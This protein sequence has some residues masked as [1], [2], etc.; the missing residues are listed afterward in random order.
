MNTSIFPILSVVGL[1]LLVQP[2]CGVEPDHFD[3][4]T[5]VRNIWGDPRCEALLRKTYIDACQAID[6][7][8]F[9]EILPR[10]AALLI[11]VWAPL[12]GTDCQ[13]TL[14]KGI[15]L[16]KGG[17]SHTLLVDVVKNED[18]TARCLE[19]SLQTE[20]EE[21]STPAPESILYPEGSLVAEILKT[22]HF[23]K[24]LD[25]DSRV[26]SLEVSFGQIFNSGSLERGMGYTANIVL[27]KKDGAGRVVEKKGL[28][29]QAL[30]GMDPV[31]NNVEG[32][33]KL[34]PGEKVFRSTVLEQMSAITP[35]GFSP[36]IWALE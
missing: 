26:E 7:S 13:L 29:Y 28:L 8:K 2:I 22:P 19:V 27:Q 18:G 24:K 34:S 32:S 30:S 1:L 31:E 6:G 16:V 23:K 5:D 10:A 17:P 25:K 33:I 21:G 4:V 12:R 11:P 15:V 20:F 3:T 9:S 35:P 14:K 36:A